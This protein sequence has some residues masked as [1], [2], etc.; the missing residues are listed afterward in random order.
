MRS[1]WPDRPASVCRTSVLDDGSGDRQS[2]TFY[3]YHPVYGGATTV[4]ESGWTGVDPP[5]AGGES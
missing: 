4:T 2:C 3:S 1:A 5:P